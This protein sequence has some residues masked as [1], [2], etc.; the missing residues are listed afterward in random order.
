MEYSWKIWYFATGDALTI[1][2]R[3]QQSLRAYDSHC[4]DRRWSTDVEHLDDIKM[5]SLI[6]FFNFEE[7]YLVVLQA[8]IWDI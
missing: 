5:L 2:W 4:I 7:G 8:A 6:M 1:G 3:S